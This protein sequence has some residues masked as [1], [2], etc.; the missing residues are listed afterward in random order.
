LHEDATI[1]AASEAR[2]LVVELLCDLPANGAGRFAEITRFQLSA[3]AS[4]DNGAGGGVR[5]RLRFG[6]QTA[7]II[8]LCA[9]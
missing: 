9:V 6:G 5:S 4:V 1:T 7:E 8:G 3:V 2:V